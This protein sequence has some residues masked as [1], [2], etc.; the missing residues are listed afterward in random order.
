MNPE[1]F[2]LARGV[3]M[4][5]SP[6]LGGQRSDEFG[7]AGSDICQQQVDILREARRSAITIRCERA[8]ECPTD[9]Q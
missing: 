7:E 2:P 4:A 1:T 6:T 9:R 3:P 5:H 8:D